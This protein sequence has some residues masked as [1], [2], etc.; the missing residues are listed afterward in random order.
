LGLSRRRNRIELNLEFVKD[1]EKATAEVNFLFYL[2][3]R[4]LVASLE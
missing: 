1:F 3:K 4:L 2:E